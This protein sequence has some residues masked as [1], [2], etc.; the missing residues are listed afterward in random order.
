M[1]KT[2]EILRLRYEV[3]LG[4]RQIARSL[5]IAHS[6]VADILRR[7]EPLESA[8]HYRIWTRV[9]LKRR[10]TLVIRGGHVP[11]LS[12]NGTVFTR[13]CERRE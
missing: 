2:K 5:S 8:G 9:P 7:A 3:G 12:Q 4:N 10:S 1:R 13:N 11:G 6:T